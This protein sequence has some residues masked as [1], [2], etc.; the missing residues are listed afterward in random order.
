MAEHEARNDAGDR[1]GPGLS[2]VSPG[3]VLMRRAGEPR[4]YPVPLFAG[5]IRP[6]SEHQPP[7]SC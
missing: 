2:E 5:T 3:R 6:Y 7:S 4:S 1:I